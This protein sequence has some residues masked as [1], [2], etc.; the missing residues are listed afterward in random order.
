MSGAA[1][2]RLGVSLIGA[3]ARGPEAA[4][5]DI[6]R[7]VPG[8][9]IER[10]RFALSN[11]VYRIGRSP[12]AQLSLN[13]P[14]A[15]IWHARIVWR[16]QAWWIEDLGSVT[17]TEVAGHRLRS[18]RRRLRSGD[19]VKLPGAWIA[20]SAPGTD[21]DEGLDPALRAQLDQLFEALPQAHSPAGPRPGR[22]AALREAYIELGVAA[23]VSLL[24]AASLAL[25]WW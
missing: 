5:L 17:G 18:G 21:P 13:D 14:R 10:R 22:L 16:C 4:L 12:D 15:S 9:A 1:S 23:A 19:V 20:F 11:D 24:L 2:D 6:E 3:P 7:V 25:L 8:P